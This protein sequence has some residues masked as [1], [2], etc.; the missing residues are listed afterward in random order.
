MSQAV[1]ERRSILDRELT[2][3][4]FLAM[5]LDMATATLIPGEQ[6]FFDSL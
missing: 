3:C 2:R 6:D 4:I 5:V 1:A